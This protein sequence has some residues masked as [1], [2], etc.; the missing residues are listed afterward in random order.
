MWESLVDQAPVNKRGWV[1]Q[2]RLLAPRVLHF[3]KGQIA[4]EC[5]E[6]EAAEGLPPGVPSFRVSRNDNLAGIQLKGLIPE[7]HGKALRE[8]RLGQTSEPDPHLL[9]SDA[10]A[11]YS[12]EL[13]NRIVEI[14]SKLDFTKEGDKLVA[15]SGMAR[16]MS[17]LIEAEYVAGLWQKHLASQLLWRVEPVFNQDT[18]AITHPSRRAE[19][20]RAPSFSWAS[21]D[22]QFGNGISCGE[23]TDRD[24]LIDIVDVTQNGRDPFGLVTGSTIRLWGKIRKIKLWKLLNG[25]YCWALKDLEIVVRDFDAAKLVKERHTNVYLDCPEADDIF[26]PPDS[27]PRNDIYCLPV[28]YGAR[29]DAEESKYLFCLLLQACKDPVTQ[30]FEGTFRRIGMTKLSPWADKLTRQ[31][32][33]VSSVADVLLP[34]LNY[35]DDTGKHEIVI[36]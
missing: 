1:L 16:K 17:D 8:D 15:L 9:R 30:E 14:Y 24:I 13:W 5:S 29:V 12:F 27:P 36:I 22:A 23:V 25:R 10:R 31:H 6:F 32:V 34:H 35:R 20:D 3:C 21:I 19:V 26:E 7:K 4:W 28:S 2:E 11:M 18:R 33:L